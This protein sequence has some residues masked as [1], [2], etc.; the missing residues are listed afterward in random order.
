MWTRFSLQRAREEQGM[1]QLLAASRILVGSVSHEVC[2]VSGAIAVIHENLVRGGLLNRNKDFEALGSMVETLNKIA[3]LELKQSAPELQPN[4]IDV[5]ETLGDLRI[6]LDPYCQE[7]DVCVRWDIPAEL[8]R[9]WADR[10]RLL[11]VLLNLTRNSKRA[12]EGADRK[13]LSIS[14]SSQGDCV[15]IRVAD[16]GPGISSADTLFQPFQQG[17][18]ATGLGLYLSRALM[19][20]VNGDLRHDPTVP[21]CCFLIKLAVAHSAENAWTE[22]NGYETSAG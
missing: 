2:N 4:G 21:G 9:V 22:N 12:L 7:A 6:V 19:R 15:W 14:A 5:V 17:A 13:E 1:E 11:Q 3:S 8:P 20:S 10:H 18:E 16:T